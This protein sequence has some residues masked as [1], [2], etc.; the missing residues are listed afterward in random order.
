MHLDPRRSD[1]LTREDAMTIPLVSVPSY[2][3]V[4]LLV[5]SLC[6]GAFAHQR[7]QDA[8][9]HSDCA[10]PPV[11]QGQFE[12]AWTNV[13]AMEMLR[14]WQDDARER[15]R[16][17][18]LWDY[19]FIPAYS[20]F[21]FVM[22]SLVAGASCAGLGDGGC[23]GVWLAYAQLLAGLLDMVE[24]AGLLQLLKP[25]PAP[26]WAP[27]ASSCASVKLLIVIAGLGYV[28]RGIMCP[29]LAR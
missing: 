18:V 22:C 27:L 29:L 5:A 6:L 12:L 28:I 4:I 16:L 19:A 25:D 3:L 9:K 17:V 1:R 26:F 21:L 13:R 11:N 7:M 20:M 24:N 14:R 8:A 10:V 15:M 2:L 23:F